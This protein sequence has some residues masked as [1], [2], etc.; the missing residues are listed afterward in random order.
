MQ[1]T[2]WPQGYTNKN[3]AINKGY[4]RGKFKILGSRNIALVA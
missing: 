2:V 3:N 1:L 4:W